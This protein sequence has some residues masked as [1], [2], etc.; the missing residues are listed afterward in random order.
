[1][2]YRRLG[3]TNENVSVLGFGCMR[4]PTLNGE[5]GNIDIEKSVE[6]VRYAIDNGVN[7]LDTAFFYHSGNS[8]KFVAKV[9][10]D[11]Y[12]EKAFVAT[13]LPLGNVNCEEDVEKL[14]VS[15]SFKVHYGAYSD[16]TRENAD[17]VAEE[18][19]DAFF[20]AVEEGYGKIT[21]DDNYIAY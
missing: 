5:D 6:M 3:K 11:G 9:I 8:E 15:E 17:D 7:Y 20:Y 16:E 2:K 12:R 21:L 10:K 18:I 14:S 13:K 4:L 1:M 19:C